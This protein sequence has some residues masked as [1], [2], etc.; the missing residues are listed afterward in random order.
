M[1]AG[2]ASGDILSDFFKSRNLHPE[3]KLGK[4]HGIY[5]SINQCLTAEP[6][7]DPCVIHRK[8]HMD[9][10]ITVPLDYMLKLWQSR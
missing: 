8:D 10:Y 6:D 4:S 2:Q 3:V 9:W 1:Q 7:A 5:R